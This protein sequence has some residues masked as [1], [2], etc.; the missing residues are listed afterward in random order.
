M[1]QGEVICSFIARLIGWGEAR[2]S[3][4]G[5]CF[6]QRPLR[7]WRKSSSKY[8]QSVK[9][10]ST[11]GITGRC[12]PLGA[13]FSF[14]CPN[15]RFGGERMPFRRRGRLRALGLCA[16]SQSKNTPKRCEFSRVLRANAR[17]CVAHVRQNREKRKTCTITL[18]FTRVYYI[19]YS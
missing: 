3:P 8:E 6:T 5:C 4:R 13:Y 2:C 17:P 7:K 14:S 19:I 10:S 16:N 1:L 15:R 11:G 9:F 18:T 12:R